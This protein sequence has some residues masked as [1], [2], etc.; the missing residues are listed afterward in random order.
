[1]SGDYISLTGAVMTVI[2]VLMLAYWC[3]RVLG[4]NWIRSSSGRNLKVIEQLQ[5][6]ADR[7]L[8]LVKLKDQVFLIGVSAAG[9]QMLAEVEGEF[10]EITAQENSVGGAGFGDFMKKYASLHQRKKGGDK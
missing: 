7:Q 4:R 5:V 10:D 9:I 3:S 8:L 1:M 2:C 6:G